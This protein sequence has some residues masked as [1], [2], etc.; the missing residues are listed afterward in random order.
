M[1][2]IISKNNKTSDWNKINFYPNHSFY[3][4]LVLLQNTCL[5]TL[6]LESSFEKWCHEDDYPERQFFHDA[7]AQ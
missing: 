5:I 6:K 4:R 1:L 2:F 7:A 3:C